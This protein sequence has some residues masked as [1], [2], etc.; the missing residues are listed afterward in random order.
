ME[1]GALIGYVMMG[2]ISLSFP[3]SNDGGGALG[4]G[5]AA[6]V[7]EVGGFTQSGSQR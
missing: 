5:D 2:V 3:E 7:A 4:A 6:D 1:V